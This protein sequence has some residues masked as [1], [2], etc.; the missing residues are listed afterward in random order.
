[1]KKETN[2]KIMKLSD[3]V[4]RTCL[5]VFIWRDEKSLLKYFDEEHLVVYRSSNALF[6]SSDDWSINSIIMK[7]LSIPVF[8]HELNHFITDNFKNKGIK[9]DETRSYMMGYYTEMFLNEIKQHEK[10]NKRTNRAKN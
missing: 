8:I 10:R 1:M 2:V 6:L 5:S 4:F 7:Q 9:D 3:P